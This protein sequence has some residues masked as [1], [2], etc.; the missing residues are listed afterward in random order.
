MPRQPPKRLLLPE[1][2]VLFCCYGKALV[3]AL[4]DSLDE[5]QALVRA[6]VPAEDKRATRAA[7]KPF[8]KHAARVYWSEQHRTHWFQMAVP[9][10]MP[11]VL[12]A[13]R[14][15]PELLERIPRA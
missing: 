8:P 6:R 14:I 13:D 1:P 10:E 11:Y 9:P 15:P 12:H 2:E 5:M 3:V 7:R 4:S